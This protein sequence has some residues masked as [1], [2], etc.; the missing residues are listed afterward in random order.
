MEVKEEEKQ[1][2]FTAASFFEVFDVL[3]GR[4]ISYRVVFYNCI[5]RI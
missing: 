4:S 3:L 1:N 2:N 5:S